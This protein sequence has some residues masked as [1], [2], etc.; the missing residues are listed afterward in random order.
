MNR[1]NFLGTGIIS[2][3]A[4]LAVLPAFGQQEPAAEKQFTVGTEIGKNHGHALSLT[5]QSVILTM[6][7]ARKEGPVLMDIKG[8]SG[9]PHTVLLSLNDLVDLL[10]LG[11]VEIESSK[12]AGHTHSV[13][14]TLIAPIA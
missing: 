9:H 5:V 10:S 6:Q 13:K 7:Q 4:V 1:R 3:A 12:D 14:I 11:S 8:S 2:S